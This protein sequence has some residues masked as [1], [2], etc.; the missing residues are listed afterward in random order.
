MTP[1][2]I[3]ISRPL[4]PSTPVWAGDT[5]F[6]LG[7]T[8]PP[9]ASATAVS[10]FRLSPH[11][12][13]HVD[14]PLHF[15]PAGSDVAA[16]PLGVCVGPCE[17]VALPGQARAIAPDDLPPGWRP[18]T[19]RVLFATGS[20]PAGSP[21]PAAFAALTPALVDSLADAGVVAIGVDSPSVDPAGS[22][23]FDAHHRCRARGVLIIE[24][25]DLTGVAPGSYT[26][27]AAP[28]RIEGAEASPV[29][30][31]LLAEEA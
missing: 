8:S 25:L 20:W 18:A 3:D 24:G 16:V 5:P 1:R 26:L 17:V 21:V 28:L 22:E 7:W 10:W 14:A 11:I 29:R 6:T 13:T 19:P 31:L 23:T 15:D 4:G 30:A 2:I 27:V 9:G 12:G